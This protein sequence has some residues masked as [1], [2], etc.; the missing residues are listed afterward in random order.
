MNGSANEFVPSTFTR[1][2]TVSWDAQSAD[3]KLNL[4]G[5]VSIPIS[6]VYRI[7]DDSLDTASNDKLDQAGDE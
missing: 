2:E 1:V 3:L 7:G 5:N 6:Q 4:S